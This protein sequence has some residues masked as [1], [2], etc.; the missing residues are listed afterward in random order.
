MTGADEEVCGDILLAVGEA[1]T[2]SAE[3]AHDG[4][5][6]P[7]RISLQADAVGDVLRFTLS[8][9]GSWKTPVDSQGHRGHGIQLM[10]ALVDGVEVTRTAEG[11]TVRWSRI[12]LDEGV[13]GMNQGRFVVT[14]AAADQPPVVTVGGDVDLAN[15]S[16]FEE[17]MSRA[18]DGATDLTVDLTGV[19]YCDSSAVRALFS[20]AATTKLTMIVRSTGHIRTLLGISG[21]DRVATLVTKD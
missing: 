1:A 15:V 6:R 3:H 9:N 5:G 7:V 16:E 10:N 20:L 17:A 8:D 13:G 2:N 4:T 11:T 19:S 18:A 21:L 14:V 12:S